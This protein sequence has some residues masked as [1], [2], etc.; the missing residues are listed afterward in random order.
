MEA[1]ELEARFNVPT[2]TREVVFAVVAVGMGVI[3]S[4][5]SPG[6]L[7]FFEL[8][9]VGE[10]LPL[11]VFGAYCVLLGGL[12][13]AIDFLRGPLL[14]RRIAEHAQLRDAA[15]RDFCLARLTPRSRQSIQV[16]WDHEILLERLDRHFAHAIDPGH[17]HLTA[18]VIGLVLGCVGFLLQVA[19]SG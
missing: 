5:H 11:Q 18:K 14:R 6:M 7:N 19:T 15:R 3:A 16:M 4:W 2:P 17:T 1:F 13:L 12:Y 8:Q 9:T 10:K